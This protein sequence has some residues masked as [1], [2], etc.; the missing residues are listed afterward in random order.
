ML[1][2]GAVGGTGLFID[3]NHNWSINTGSG[4]TPLLR[5]FYQQLVKGRRVL[6]ADDVRNTGQVTAECVRLLREAG[7]TPI[8]VLCI[9]DRLE[10]IVDPGVPVFPLVH[11]PAPPNYPAGECPLCRAGKPITRF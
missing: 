4:R 5:P 1:H 7:G 2:A 6:V 10:S 3:G 9:C 11:Y 8:A